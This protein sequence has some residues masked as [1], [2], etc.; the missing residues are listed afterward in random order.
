MLPD[1][2]A[3]RVVAIRAKRAGATGAYPLV[4][5][6]VAFFLFF[7]PLAQRVHQL[8]P[9]HGLQLL[10]F[11]LAQVFFYL[12]AQPVFR[13]GG[14]QVVQAGFDAVCVLGKYAVE[15]VVVFFILYQNSARQVVKRVHTGK[16][17]PVL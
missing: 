1:A 10:L 14:L 8:V 17:Q 5:A 9:A 12:L 13:D 3:F 7:Q 11:F 4:A 15:A 2:D 16:R 6:L